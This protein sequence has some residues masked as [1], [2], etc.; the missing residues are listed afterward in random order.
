MKIKKNKEPAKNSSAEILLL[1][2]FQS[3]YENNKTYKTR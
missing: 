2:M 3:Y 1:F